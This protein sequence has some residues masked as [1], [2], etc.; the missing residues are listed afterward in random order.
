MQ[1]NAKVRSSRFDFSNEPLSWQRFEQRVPRYCLSKTDTTIPIVSKKEVTES[2]VY[3]SD[4]K[5]KDRES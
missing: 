3:N 5:N 1:S 4:P 2:E